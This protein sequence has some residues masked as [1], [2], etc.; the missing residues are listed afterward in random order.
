MASKEDILDNNYMNK[1]YHMNL[2]YFMAFLRKKYVQEQ[3]F[4]KRNLLIEDIFV[5][6]LEGLRFFQGWIKIF[7]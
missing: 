4:D 3:I 7:F 6:L 2:F 1:R 5:E